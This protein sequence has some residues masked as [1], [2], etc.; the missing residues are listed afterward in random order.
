M[1]EEYIARAG[2]LE[3]FSEAMS[4]PWTDLEDLYEIVQNTQ[5][6]NVVE[7]RCGTWV[8]TASFPMGST[9]SCPFCGWSQDNVDPVLWLTHPLHKFCGCCGADLRGFNNVQTG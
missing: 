9:V 3:V 8:F 5:A 1:V 6:A 7:V 2:L 4:H